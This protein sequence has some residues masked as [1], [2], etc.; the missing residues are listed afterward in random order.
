MLKL[1]TLKFKNIGRFV[2]EQ[3]IDFSDLNGLIQVDAENKNTG[4]S[5][6]AG[7]STI[8]NALEYL[9]DI[10]DLPTT[11]LQSRLT[12]ESLSVEGDFDLDGRPITIKRSKKGLI[13]E[14][15]DTTGGSSKLSEEKL[16]EILGMSGDL[17][18]VLMHKRQKEGGF[19]LNFTPKETYE[20]L[21]DAKDLKSYTE[22][23]KAID[24]DIKKLEHD[25]ASTVTNLTASETGLA[26]SEAAFGT[27]GEPPSTSTVTEANVVE[28]K[29]YWEETE[30]VL[31]AEETAHSQKRKAL[32]AEKPKFEVRSYDTTE[33]R[34]LEKFQEEV[35]AKVQSLT[36]GE[37]NRQSVAKDEL[38]KMK[39]AL[40][41]FKNKVEKGQQAKI[42]ARSIGLEL[43]KLKEGICPTCEQTWIT[44]T[45]KT[46]QAKLMEDLESQKAIFLA[47]IHAAS[48]SEKTEIAIKEKTIELEPHD[49]PGLEGFH[50]TLGG[51]K[52]SIEQ[53]KKLQVEFTNMVSRE[54]KVEND[55][56]L[57]KVQ[58]LNSKLSAEMSGLRTKVFESKQLFNDIFNAFESAKKSA[59]D[60]KQRFKSLESNKEKYA[61]SI[62]KLTAEIE[63]LK[64]RY[65]IAQEAKLVVKSFISC[66]FD[67][68]LESIGDKATQIIRGVPTMVTATIQLDGM[69]ETQEGAVK[70]EVTAV[71]HIDGEQ[72][73]PIKSLSGGERSAVDLAIDLA[74]IDFLEDATGKG[75]DLFI[76]DEPFTGLDSVSIEQVLEVLQASNLNKKLI[77][78]DHNDIIKQFIQNKILVVREGDTSNVKVGV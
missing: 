71:I 45:I 17:F 68:A 31:K 34:R 64:E 9:L 76:L 20:F 47:S 4:G 77:I 26:A 1:K 52:D 28:A 18:R 62:T 38:N 63:D 2:E 27:L 74:V 6:G 13:I 39:V 11:I 35:K 36:M 59:S 78:V 49:I 65:Q 53:H 61:S 19:F 33:M 58:D 16:S 12:K 10:N 8:F 14:D 21:V 67:D 60:Y 44:D 48:D 30:K 69:R 5:S 43:K 50:A 42:K 24:L 25:I 37:L 72:A 51:V 75:V 23:S 55:N 54:Q 56:Y 46:K 73:I 40:I 70:E 29:E 32:D 41:G 15:G 57:A 7:K 3:V 22:K 66:S